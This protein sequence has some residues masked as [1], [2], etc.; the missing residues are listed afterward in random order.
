MKITKS[1]LR[2][3]IKEEVQRLNEIDYELGSTDPNAPESLVR[4]IRRLVSAVG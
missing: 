2:Q 1:R 3:I 4:V